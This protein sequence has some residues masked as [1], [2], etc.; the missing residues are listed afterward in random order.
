MVSVEKG[1]RW[2]YEKDGWKEIG[3]FV[4]CLVFYLAFPLFDGP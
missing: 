2:L 4:V 3:L 1:K